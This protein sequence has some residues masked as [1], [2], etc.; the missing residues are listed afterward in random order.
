MPSP[1]ASIN[2]SSFLGGEWS[3]R[4]QGRIDDPRY[5]TAMALC[6]NA[7][8]VEEGAVT[9][10][11]GWVAIGPTYF[12]KPGIVRK[13]AMAD[14]RPLIL[15][16]TW[17]E[18]SSTS[19]L[20]VWT[21]DYLGF[22][23]GNPGG[24]ILHYDS[25][26][27]ITAISTA[28]PAVV[29]TEATHTWITGD[30]VQLFID[31]TLPAA[32]GGAMLTGRPCVITVIDD[33]HFSIVDMVTNT[34]VNGSLLTLGSP[35]AS[36]ISH[37]TGL[38]LPY[39]SLEEVMNCKVV[40]E[41]ADP[42]LGQEVGTFAFFL[43]QSQ[44]PYVLSVTGLPLVLAGMENLTITLN[45]AVFIDGPYMNPLPGDS[46][47]GNSLGSVNLDEDEAH[48][49]FT[50]TDG[51]YSFVAGDLDRLIRL[52]YQ[53]PAWS[54]SGSYSVGNYV[55]Y[56]GT[57]WQL[58][59]ADGGSHTQPGSSYISGGVAYSPWELAPQAGAW[60][61]GLITDV[62][63]SSEVQTSL[64]T[65]PFTFGVGN[66]GGSWV[67]DTWALGLYEAGQY[68][69]CG[70][71]H[72]GRLMLAG[73]VPGRFDLA[74]LIE[75]DYNGTT[76]AAYTN[77]IFFSPSDEYGQVTDAHAI[78]YTLKTKSSAQPI[79]WGLSDTQGIFC[80]TQ[81]QEWLI[82]A[83]NISDP[84]TPTDIQAHIVTRNGAS[85]V[86][87]LHIG[88][89]IVFVQTYGRRVIEV[90]ADF[91]SG[92][93]L[94]GRHLN[95]YAKHLFPSPLIETT[96]QREP[97]PVVW[98]I[99]NG[100]LVGCT[101]RR[102]S[103]LPSQPPEIFGWHKHTHGRGNTFLSTC[104]TGA[105]YGG[106]GL[107][108][109]SLDSV[110]AVTQDPNTG[111]CFVEVMTTVLDEEVEALGTL[112]VHLDGAILGGVV[113]GTIGGDTSNPIPPP[114]PPAAGKYY[115]EVK[116]VH[117]SPP[118]G[119]ANWQVGV[120]DNQS[121][122]VVAQGGAHSAVVDTGNNNEALI[123]GSAYTGG[124]W[125][126]T[127]DSHVIGVAVDTVNALIWWKDVT[128]GGVW[129]T[130]AASANPATGIGGYGISGLSGSIFPVFSGSSISATDEATINTGTSAFTGT[131][132]SGFLAWDTSG[133]CVWN[134]GA[135]GVIS[136]FG[137]ITLS[138]G[139]STL[140]MAISSGNLTATVV[141]AGSTTSWLAAS[142]YSAGAIVS[143]EG[144]IWY[145]PGGA[146][147]NQTPGVS[148]DWVRCS[149][150][151]RGTTGIPQ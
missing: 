3:Q 143:Y 34:P 55:T 70:E 139:L 145:T 31:P 104:S 64:S 79:Q 33:Q 133:N 58:A 38:P 99:V 131:L 116:R 6:L 147:T 1:G 72:E 17:D 92:G 2:V 98:G 109:G 93:K 53:P 142:T 83:S 126:G 91:Y 144:L 11:P 66:P 77:P 125:S 12:N 73:A 138:P 81:E 25:A 112:G 96:Y 46:Q 35:G 150:A 44:P 15:E 52:W 84:L 41:D 7:L 111:Q 120:C 103:N 30:V 124:G 62:V 117:S 127:S 132:P 100:V 63:S 121:S 16:A 60:T 122:M 21:P 128:A 134:P 141:C 94:A 151:V 23:V 89:A 67:I 137:N 4:S 119:G 19:Q 18:T 49:D 76:W 95:E 75:P 40:Q 42:V 22:N 9:R 130:G 135:A 90:L 10:R 45:V 56:Q 65:T 101:Y 115:F 118:S 5:R 86:D 43:H 27:S 54:G 97:V 113:G 39:T 61:F 48:W 123:C 24:M 20:W 85:A 29:A 78:A 28:T 114:S 88:H 82:S 136:V 57:F 106:G 149:V 146:G 50:I 110:A 148:S 59:F 36:L 32:D 47:T 14:N 13:F 129:N 140:S 68:P 108:V 87:P 37:I 102:H 80:G 71:F 51:A 69:A 8:P 74:A 105:Y 26:D 107:A